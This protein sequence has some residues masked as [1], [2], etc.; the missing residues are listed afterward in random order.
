MNEAQA[1]IQLEA[2]REELQQRMQRTHRHIYQKDEAVSADFHEQVKQTENDALVY[3]LEE[4]GRQELQ[5][6]QH[7][8]KR[9]EEGN[10]FSCS[11]CGQA[12]N[13]DRLEAIPYTEYC[14]KCA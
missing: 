14:I 9:L 12:I 4:E 3:T 10:Y 6:I 13:P 11:A 8:L 1:R 7:A 2:L 5:Q